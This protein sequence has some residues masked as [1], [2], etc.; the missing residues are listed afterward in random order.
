MI[1]GLVENMAYMNCPCCGNP[2]YPFGPTKLIEVADHYGIRPIASLPINPEIA[3]YVD[4]GKLEEADASSFDQ[5]RI[6]VEEF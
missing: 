4:N 3:K 2:I 6:A 5:V 1:L